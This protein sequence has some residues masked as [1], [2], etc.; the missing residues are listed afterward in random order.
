MK[1]TAVASEVD[2]GALLGGAQFVDAYRIV[3][4]GTTLDARQAAEKMFARGP[5]WI[6]VLLNLRNMAI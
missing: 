1:I 3:L 6:N 2:R 4:D 5:R